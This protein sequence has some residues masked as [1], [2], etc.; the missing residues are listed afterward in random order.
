MSRKAPAWGLAIV[1]RIVD[2][3]NGKIWVTDDLLGV[4]FNFFFDVENL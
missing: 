2:R 1:D 4:T 3:H